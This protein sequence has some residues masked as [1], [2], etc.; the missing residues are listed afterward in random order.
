VY[1][2][3]AEAMQRGIHALAIVAYTPEEFNVSSH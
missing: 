1:D 3:L 2:A